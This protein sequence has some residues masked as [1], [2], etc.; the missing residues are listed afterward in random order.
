LARRQVLKWASNMGWMPLRFR[1]LCVSIDTTAWLHRARELVS[2]ELHE[3]ALFEH[4]LKLEILYQRIGRLGMHVPDV[5][6]R[7]ATSTEPLRDAAIRAIE[8]LDGFK[9]LAE[10]SG[11]A[12]GNVN[13]TMKRLLDVCQYQRAR[14]IFGRVR[15]STGPGA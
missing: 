14:N 7:T 2:P 3:S 9:E 1:A 11:F 8:Y 4:M 6:Y 12:K 5:Q 10:S 15:D 13:E